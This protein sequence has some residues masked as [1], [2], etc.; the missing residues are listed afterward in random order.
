MCNSWK[1]KLSITLSAKKGPLK[2]AGWVSDIVKTKNQILYSQMGTIFRLK[3]Y[4]VI[5]NLKFGSDLDLKEHI[6]FSDLDL[7]LKSISF[8]WS[9][10][11][12]TLRIKITFT[13]HLRLQSYRFRVILTLTC[14]PVLSC[15]DVWICCNVALCPLTEKAFMV[16][17]TSFWSLYIWKSDKKISSNCLNGIM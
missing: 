8:Q 12:R 3:N 5:L 1:R 2:I 15:R 14:Q 6:Y 9:W 10:S 16:V 13:R 17:M 7:D 11:S 4:V